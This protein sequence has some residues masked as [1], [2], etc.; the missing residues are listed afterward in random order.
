VVKQRFPGFH[1]QINARS[2]TDLNPEIIRKKLGNLSGATTIHN[3]S[4]STPL[5]SQKSH[6]STFT[7]TTT[8]R[9]KETT[10]SSS[11]PTTSQRPI[12]PFI[13]S[14][15]SSVKPQQDELES[16]GDLNEEHGSSRSTYQQLIGDRFENRGDD[17]K[18]LTALST[19]N[20]SKMMMMNRGDTSLSD[21][22][23]KTDR[24]QGK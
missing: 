19:S 24:R 3:I 12:Q 5:T 21:I 8:T 10:T 1:L 15:T 7:P 6:P 22:T 14:K 13:P 2:Y 20:E 11:T 23:L 9:I 16:H 18:P 17:M 4:S